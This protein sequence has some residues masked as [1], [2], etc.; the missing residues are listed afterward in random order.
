MGVHRSTGRVGEHVA[1]VVVADG[2]ELGGLVGLPCLEDVEGGRVEVDGAPGVGGLA[3]GFVEL[4]AD[5][6]EPPVDRQAGL[7]VVEVA[8]FE[9]EQFAA[10]HAGGCREPQ[11][12]EQAVT[13]S[14][15]QER[16][17]LVSGPG[18]AFDR[19]KR[20]LQR[21]SGVE[22]DVAVDQAPA[23]GVAERRE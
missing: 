19:R 10:A 1:G 3:A 8:P 4:V 17:E 21:R 14:G 13:S 18:L 9:A 6:D 2:G 5:G 7:V 22:G 11:R 12:R 15:L 20:A 16:P 23:H